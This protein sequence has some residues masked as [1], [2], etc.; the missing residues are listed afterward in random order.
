MVSLIGR[1]WRSHLAELIQGAHESLVIAAPY[2]KRDEAAWVCNLLSPNVDVHTLA[3]VQTE[4]VENSSLDIAAL[5]L[6]SQASRDS[7]VYALPS[8][9]AKVYVAD[10]TAAIVTSGN[11]TRAGLD[12]NLE[13]GLAIQVPELTRQIYSDMMAYRQLGSPVPPHVV[14]SLLEL[15]NH[16]RQAR[17]GVVDSATNAAKRRFEDVLEQAEDTFTAIQVGNRTKNSVFS[18]AILYALADSRPHSTQEVQQAIQQL[19]PDLCQ[20]DKD[21]VINGRHFGKLWK[22]DVRNAQQ[23]LK[24]QGRVTYDAESQTWSLVE[25]RRG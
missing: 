12:R 23:Y 19:L 15:E 17:A 22:H 21:R 14:A 1:G 8:L 7:S 20:D 13:Y 5:S 3:H 25:T 4:A 9:H 2:I 11:L 18:E 16:I 6:L 10:D 24:G